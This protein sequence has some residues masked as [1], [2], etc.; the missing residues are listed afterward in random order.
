MAQLYCFDR[1]HIKNDQFSVQIWTY[2]FNKIFGKILKHLYNIGVN[3]LFQIQLPQFKF[4][5]NNKN[6]IKGVVVWCDR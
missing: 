6:I 4:V 5:F 1:L 2:P 3:L